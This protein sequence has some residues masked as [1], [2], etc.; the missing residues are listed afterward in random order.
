MKK[1]RE[2]KSSRL[3]CIA[4]LNEKQQN[5][6]VFIYL[7]VRFSFSMHDT[8]ATLRAESEEQ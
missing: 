4:S 6:N 7:F 8:L 3:N 5:Q 1:K 2:V